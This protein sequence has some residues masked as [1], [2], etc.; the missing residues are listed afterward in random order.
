MASLAQFAERYGKRSA[1]PQ[2]VAKAAPKAV[3][4]Q[5]KTTAPRR[6]P[7]APSPAVTE[8]TTQSIAV[9]QEAEAAERISTAF[10]SMLSFTTL[11][12]LLFVVAAITGVIARALGMALAEHGAIGLI[13][14]STA[15]LTTI[16]V[17]LGMLPWDIHGW[18]GLSHHVSPCQ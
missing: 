4:K 12:L 13:T 7:V 16:V 5:A 2:A 17:S 8:K 15:L 9:L 10:G 18:Q 11:P 3:P 1:P 6:P 14:P